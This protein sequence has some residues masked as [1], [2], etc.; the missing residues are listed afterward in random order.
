MKSDKTDNPLEYSR[1]L[2]VHKWSDYPEVTQ[3]VAT[4]ARELSGLSPKQKKHL[5]VVILDLYEAW[6]HD[7]K[8]YV[9][10]SRDRNNYQVDSR[11]SKLHIGYTA[12]IT[13]IDKL[14]QSGYLEHHK[15][16]YDRRT[17]VGFQ[18]RM[19]ATRKLIDLIRRN[20][21]VEAYMIERVEGEEIIL[22]KDKDGQLV[23]YNDTPMAML[24]R[25][26][27]EVINQW[28]ER[29]RIDLVIPDK[30]FRQ[31]LQRLKRDPERGSLDFSRK[32]LKRIFNNSSFEE[33]GRFYHGWWQEIP[34]EYRKHI[35]I[36]GQ[37]TVELDYSGMHLRLLYAKAGLEQQS[38]PYALGMAEVPRDKVKRIVNILLNAESLASA[39]KAI[40]RDMG[41]GSVIEEVLEKIFK[42]HDPIRQHFYS[43]VGVELQYWD[44]MIAEQVMLHMYGHHQTPV[45]PVHDS[46]LVGFRSKDKLREAMKVV[47]SEVSLGAIPLITD[48]EMKEWGMKRVRGQAELKQWLEETKGQ[49]VREW[50]E[51]MRVQRAREKHG[52]LHSCSVHTKWKGADGT[53]EENEQWVSIE[54]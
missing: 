9:G 10:Y 24:M 44:S 54:A 42:R 51:A 49:A 6:L 31:L 14:E 16:F 17:G 8:L 35:T 40:T 33:G 30:D 22:L 15:G 37:P 1:P 29:T 36:N 12:L 7:P 25:A 32:R 19:R 53:Q 23:E 43:G 3:A 11:Y 34:R 20:R 50:Q 52:E 48:K 38:D 13:I 47:F 26:Q 28:L 5:K 4:L 45:L 2:D 46:F 27:L 41:L 39:K 21:K 18:S